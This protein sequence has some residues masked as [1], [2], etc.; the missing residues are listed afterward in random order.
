[1]KKAHTIVLRLLLVSSAFAVFSQCKN[2]PKDNPPSTGKTG[3]ITPVHLPETVPGF[4]FPESESVINGWMSDSS[5]TGDYDSVSIYNHAWGIWA[6]LTDPTNQ[7]YAG[8]KL[9]VFET[10]MG[11][12]EVQDIIE[13]NGTACDT[14]Y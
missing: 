14:S 6:G 13:A 5:F 7:S 12:S 11:L 10:W 9:L 8:D 1:M 2:K 4:K 3:K